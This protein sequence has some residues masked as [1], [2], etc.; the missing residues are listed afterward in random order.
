MINM[1]ST[2][3]GDAIK[4]FR[5]AKGM[6]IK[7]LS[8]AAGISE[9]HLKK[10]ETGNRQPGIRTYQKIV[11]VLGMEIVIQNEENSVKGKCI[12]KAQEILLNSTEKQAIFMTHIMEAI[13]EQIDT[14]FQ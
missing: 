6:T 3:L 12:A 1:E 10:V 4:L 11:S 9:L 7:E 8:E 5:K 13:A 2:N 14:A